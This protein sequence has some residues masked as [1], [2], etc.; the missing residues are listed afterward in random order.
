MKT[1]RIAELRALCEKATGGPWSWLN[2]PNGAKLLCAENEAV[3]HMGFPSPLNI[4]EA[5]QALIAAAPDALAEALDEIE[6]LM[7]INVKGE[8]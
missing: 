2:Y 3:I 8:G 1:E 6:R 7:Q 5:D 4:S